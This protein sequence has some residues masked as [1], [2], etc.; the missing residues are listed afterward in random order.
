MLRRIALQA[1]RDISPDST[2]LFNSNYFRI[3][4]TYVEDYKYIK[5]LA[6]RKRTERLT[7][8]GEYVGERTNVPANRLLHAGKVFSLRLFQLLQACLWHRDIATAGGAS[9]DPPQSR[10]QG[11]GGDRGSWRPF[12]P[13]RQSATPAGT[14][15]ILATLRK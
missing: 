15:A 3:R 11:G 1:E 10:D 13:N 4:F 2:A 8:I 14:Q 6:M 12:L 5:A 9:R 7:R